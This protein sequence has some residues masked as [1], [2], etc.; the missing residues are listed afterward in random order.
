MTSPVWGTARP[1]R[2]RSDPSSKKPGLPPEMMHSLPY[3]AALPRLSRPSL[4]WAKTSLASWP[5]TR[6]GGQWLRPA[7]LSIGDTPGTTQ[8]LS[9][10]LEQLTVRQV[11]GAGR[12]PCGSERSVPAHLWGLL[13]PSFT[14]GAKQP[15]SSAIVCHPVS[16]T[17]PGRP[18]G[19]RSPRG[20]RQ[21]TPEAW[22]TGLG[23]G[24]PRPLGPGVA[25]RWEVPR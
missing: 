17:G 14:Q 3:K 19:A 1:R 2:G 22:S 18:P 16:G 13:S 4:F 10:D 8:T 11:A 7:V 20:D 23:A 15:T 12:F 5:R 24:S 9:P 25:G 21:K 6:G